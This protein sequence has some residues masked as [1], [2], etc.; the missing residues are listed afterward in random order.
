MSTSIGA[1]SIEMHTDG[2][3]VL[4]DGAVPV[5][6]PPPAPM[7]PQA[8]YSTMGLSFVHRLEVQRMIDANL[9]SWQPSALNY[10]KLIDD[11]LRVA[12]LERAKS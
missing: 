9:L 4:E 10:Q 8:D 7:P 3:G 12:F 2:L 6:V 1:N 11:S 5:S